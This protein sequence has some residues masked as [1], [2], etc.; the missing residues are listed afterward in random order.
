M[1]WIKSFIITLGVF[2][3]IGLLLYL[4][5]YFPKTLGLITIIGFYGG[6][7]IFIFIV[8]MGLIKMWLE[9]RK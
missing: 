3:L 1:I 6:A 8:I 2:S 7:G 5:I 4:F 9:E